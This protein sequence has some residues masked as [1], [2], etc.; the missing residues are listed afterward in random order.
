MRRHAFVSAAALGLLAVGCTG[1]GVADTNAFSSQVGQLESQL[2]LDQAQGVPVADLAPLRARV[3]ELKSRRVAIAIPYA[4]VSAALFRN[5][6]ADLQRQRAAIV[7]RHRLQAALEHMSGGL[8][9]GMPADLAAVRATLQKSIDAAAKAVDSRDA[10]EV[11]GEIDTFPHL[12]LAA[13]VAQHDGL[14]DR[15]RASQAALD[16]SISGRREL[17]GATELAGRLAKA[18]PDSQVRTES[19]AALDQ[20]LGQSD[21]ALTADR[22]SDLQA[23]AAALLKSLENAVRSRAH[24]E[25][26]Q[27]ST[28]ADKYGLAGGDRDYSADV[29]A[30]ARAIDSSTGDDLIRAEASLR[31]LIT[32]ISDATD[33]LPKPVI[34]APVAGGCLKGVPDQYIWVHLASQTLVAYDH[35]CPIIASYITTGRAELP[36]GRG[37]F[38]IFRKA[39]AYK[40]ISPWPKTSKFWYPDAWVNYAM[41]FIG[42]GTFF[43]T[44]D[45]QPDGTYGAG[46]QYGPY[47][48]HGCVHVPWGIAAQLYNWAGIGTTVT[49]G[50]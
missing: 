1:T 15:A 33:S 47:A 11:V 30:A 26:T 8:V 20:L 28:L 24:D 5:G 6:V 3:T 10:S 9:E 7:D 46:S 49:V 36:T 44:A 40:M 31:S 19:R 45:W 38:T 21:G 23:R 13:Q 39:Y 27:A 48:S 25:A 16:R 12:T 35:G 32:E 29:D 2:N 42:D 14:R 22:L 17:D 37:T 43:H 34:P 50:D 4:A 41:E 18:L